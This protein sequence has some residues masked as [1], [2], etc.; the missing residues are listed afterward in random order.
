MGTSR[1]KRPRGL[2]LTVAAVIAVV[3]G[4]ASPA[5][6]LSG[7]AQPG[8]ALS[9]TGLS[10]SRSASGDTRDLTTLA[11]P[12]VGTTA[13]G[14]TYPGATV[15][16]GMTQP[17]PDT[18][19]MPSGGGYDYTDSKI[20]GF[21]TVHVSGPGCPAL[22]HISL[23]PVTGSVTSTTD[24]D[25]ASAFSHSSEVAR[26]GYYAVTLSRYGIRAEMTATT[27]TAWER[28]TFPAPPVGSTSSAQDQVLL[29]L[30]AAENKTTA[31]HL[32]IT[33]PD[34]VSGFQ[35]TDVFCNAG[36]APVTVYFT[37]RFSSPFASTGTWDNGPVTWGSTSAT[38]TAIGGAFRFKG[39]SR[40]VTAAIGV[41]YVS[42]GNAAQNLA[43]ETPAPST[44]STPPTPSASST[45]PTPTAAPTPTAPTAPTALFTS[46]APRT[47]PAL[48]TPTAP[49]ATSA[50]QAAQSTQTAQA[51][52]TPSGPQAPQEPSGA[53]FDEVRDIAH[54]TWNSELQR[55]DVTGGTYAQRVNFYTALYHSLIEPNVFSDVNGQ[56]YGMD[57]KIHTAQDRTEYTN[58]SL[59]DTYRTQQELLDL[60][61][62]GVARDV[63]LSIVSDTQELGWVPRWVLANEETNT[64]SG[65]SVTEIIADALAAGVVTKAQVAPLYPYLKKNA[66]QAPPAGSEA[67][68]RADIADYRKD[69]YV[70]YTLSGAYDQRA[71]ASATL[72]YA[73]AD[74]GLS[75][76]AS[77]LGH[78][79]D[80]VDFGTT[81][82]NYRSEFDPS[83]RF[84]RPR[85]P[86]G[87]YLTPFDPGQVSLPYI[88]ANALGYDE[89]SA[90]QYLWLVP[91]DP[92]DLASLLGG[93]AS[94]ISDLNQFF[95]FNQVAA[96]P[97][98][99]SQIWTG[100]ANYDATDEGDIEAPYTYDAL[101]A[102]W[103]TQAVTRAALTFY[104]AVPAG[105]PGNDDLGEM[106]AWYV[107]TALGLY[108]YAAGQ[109]VFTLTS[110]LF[111]REV[112]QLPRPFYS[113][114]PITIEAPG[115]GTY[116]Q[117]LTV[118]GQPQDASWI[119]GAQLT[120]TAGATDTATSASPTPSATGTSPT[121]RASPTP[122]ASV[123]PTTSPT[124]TNPTTSP[125]ASVTSTGPA[126]SS[127]IASASSTSGSPTASPSPGG[128][129]PSA[130]PTAA[131]PPGGA[132]LQF[133]T[134]S[135]PAKDWAAGPAG[136]FP[137]YCPGVAG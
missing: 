61:A 91:Q 113:G 130:S 4:T 83:T 69:G 52:E 90:W 24:T 53:V 49:S 137:A 59:W 68:G 63:V 14:D 94:E 67:G 124:S 78:Q 127:P 22:G 31:A 25:Y 58:L 6:A 9:V 32:T 87:S 121:T 76:I 38:G 10:G 46:P 56:Y 80:A 133:T 36:Y 15:P 70:Q 105:L 28:Y 20:L 110:P 13:G 23:M 54:A 79:A 75:H 86:D 47:A 18:S 11:D 95:A 7:A 34:T 64:M 101:G 120:G 57:G 43:A 73:L 119:S 17:S 44:P 84:F 102:A 19:S 1:T 131:T 97:D 55:V 21:S 65:D 37:A 112:I 12:L 41:S 35:S 134:G 135:S 40:Q 60:I 111:T 71:A 8:A 82:H 27:R 74:C 118:N 72:E 16:F 100:G 51:T 85:L 132:T 99:A 122:S 77:E 107:M 66:T 29:N 45:P 129:T 108:P 3:T 42:V 89:G 96:D 126:T 109:D 117:G 98:A 106:S 30:G 93:T 5:V 33:G 2:P 50:P 48:P 81:A 26:P 115:A 62:P 128:S 88:T 136:S 39:N 116:I 92:A 123:S 125:T 103:Q 104:R 114:T